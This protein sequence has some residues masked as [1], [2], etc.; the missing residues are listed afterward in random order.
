MRRFDDFNPATLFMY[1]MIAIIP[2]MVI[3]DPLL[4]A[5]ALLAGLI[6]MGIHERKFPA[7]RITFSILLVLVMTLMNALTSHQG[8][9]ELLFINN[10]AITLEAVRYGA[11]TGLMM[12]AAVVWFGAFSRSLTGEKIMIMLRKMPKTALLM[13]MIIRLI[14]RYIK[15]FRKVEEAVKVNEKAVQTQNTAGM[16]KIS[17]AVFTWALENSM[18]T[19]DV[20]IMRGCDRHMY[21]R[22]GAG[23]KRR[24]V[25]LMSIIIISQLM[26]LLPYRYRICVQWIYLIIPEIYMIK[27]NVKWKIYTLGT[28]GT[29]KF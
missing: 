16:L 9:T 18:D 21:T 4:S 14:P 24:D 11:V 22:A 10:R 1:Y 19:A 20:M 2:F 23:F 29:K 25:I 6:R 17:S 26:W 8:N 15:R 28:S 13:S 12:A 5:A 7:G 3:M 27:E